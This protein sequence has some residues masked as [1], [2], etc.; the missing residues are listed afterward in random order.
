MH[1]AAAKAGEVLD[2]RPGADM[3]WEIVPM[4]G[5]FATLNRVAGGTGGPPVHLHPDA[6]ERY[7]VLEGALDVCV[8]GAWRTLH[9]GESAIVPPGTPHTLRGH[10]GEAAVFLD[11][12]SPALEFEAF[13][14]HFHAMVSSGRITLPPKTPRAL[15]GFALLFSTYPHLQRTVSPPQAVFT[16]LGHVARAIGMR[17]DE[18]GS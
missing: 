13:F 16:A 18:S 7:E 14:R 17:L 3:T 4:D 15:L 11:V 10:A 1:T 12:H 2:F 9:A 8:D 5:A 6:E